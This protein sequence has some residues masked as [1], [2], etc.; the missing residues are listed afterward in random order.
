MRDWHDEYDGAA[1]NFHES[2]RKVRF[3]DAAQT[4]V[5]AEFSCRPLVYRLY[6]EYLENLRQPYPKEMVEAYRRG[7][8]S[9]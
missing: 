5:N 1:L 3:G 2:N 8:F 6:G 7:E 4:E 9:G